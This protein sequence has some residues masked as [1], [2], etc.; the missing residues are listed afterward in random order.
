MSNNFFKR[1]RIGD[2]ICSKG[3]AGRE[4]VEEEAGS[5]KGRLGE[6]LLS[7][8]VI[9]GEQL[10]E[11]LAL[12]FELP[13]AAPSDIAVHED[14]FEKCIVE[15]VY[16]LGIVPV[17]E[18][19]GRLAF[20][21]DDPLNSRLL[22]E[23]ERIY[24]RGAGLMVGSSGAIRSA[25]EKSEVASRFLKN[26]SVDYEA[27][28]SPGRAAEGSSLSINA[29]A[30]QES[31]VEK[32]VNTILIVAMKKRASD[33][34][35]E[36]YEDGVAVKYRIDGILYSATETLSAS[37]HRAF[38]TRLKVMA[39][40]DIAENRVP[41]DG[42]FTLNING[43]DTDFRVSILPS[44]L[45]EDI[46]IRVLD[47][48]AFE[49]RMKE[50]SL[51][52]LGFDAHSLVRFRKSI[53]EPYG[54]VLITGPT[55][56]GKTTTLYAALAELNF[57]EEKIITIEDPVEYRI[58]GIVQVPVNEKKKVT[59]AAGLRS[60]L[61]HD[62]D[63]IVV[64]EIRDPETAQIAVQSAL[65][66]HLVFTT[67]HANS[68]CDVIGRFSHMGINVHSFVSAL[69]CVVAQRLLRS[70]CP[71]CRAEYKPDASELPE[72]S[73]AGIEIRKTVWFQ[74]KGCAKCAGTGYSGRSAIAE[75]MALSPGLREM[76]TNQS[77]TAELQQQAIKEGMISLRRTAL[78]RAMRGE[79]TLREV[80]RVTFAEGL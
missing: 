72:E 4:R 5:A 79:T 47:K 32:F 15:D 45:G 61:R 41:Q 51:D 30:S 3:F 53:H 31:S 69:N 49:T 16:R 17:A 65:T 11:A 56:S 68:A 19:D 42:H 50:M 67:V 44:V 39:K 57:S 20:V 66:G 29:V 78:E 18:G 21:I 76:I 23:I 58:K 60:I 64:G 43:K 12:H 46:V 26:V 71:H 59:F 7:R 62:P 38:I 25:L 33:I 52:T 80:N 36:V 35:L 37:H 10:A 75:Y 34:H 74:G 77:P 48:S 8:G 73:I 2:V 63:K 54:M 22:G 28:E 24:G 9:N 70:I 14:V 1:P 27:P 55:G 6:W 40:L 13:Y